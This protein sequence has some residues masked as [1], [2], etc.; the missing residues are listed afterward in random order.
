[1]TYNAYELSLSN[2]EPVLLFDF[3]L[4]TKHWR[5]CTADRPIVYLANTFAN[6]AISRTAP[7]QGSEIRRQMMTVTAPE[8]LDLSDVFADYPPSGDMLLTVTALHY[9]DPDQQGIVDWIGRV[10]GHRRKGSSI[11]LS[12]EPAYTSVQTMGLRRRWALGCPHVLYGKGCTVNPN[13][14][15]QIG[16][17]SAVSGAAITV[18]GLTPPTGLSFNGGYIEWDSGKGYTER[19]SINGI[20]G[21]VFTL[22][23]G[24]PDIIVGLSI[25]VFPGCDRTMANCNSFGNISNYGGQPNMPTKNPMD[26]SLANPVY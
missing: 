23:Y 26:G 16:A 12:C 8:T 9:N 22:S 18:P 5:Y 6:V 19:R 13:T 24:S 3:A 7:V 15:K 10:V 20:S 1:M 21:S 25:S 4:G 14:Y 2:G 17:I 11:E